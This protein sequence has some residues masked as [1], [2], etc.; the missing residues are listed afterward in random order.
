MSQSIDHQ[1]FDVIVVGGGSAGIAAAISAASNGARTALIESGNLL[2]GELL[3]GMAIDGAISA[4]GEQISGGILD[5]IMERCEHLGGFVRKLNDWRLIQYV[6]YDPEIMKIAVPQ[7]VYEAGVSVFLQTFAEGVVARDGQVEGVLVRNKSGRSLL[8][9][10][11]VV[12]CSGDG[13]ICVAAGSDVLPREAEERL[14]PVSMMFRMAG[15]ETPQLLDF[16]VEHP[17][18]FA[19]GESD[20][21]RGGRTDAELAAEIKR[22]GQPCVFL[23]GDA[24]FLGGAI[25]RGDMYPTALIMIQPTSN[26]RGEV[27]VNST[28][29]TLDDPL[30][31]DN[32]ASAL[33]EL[34]QQIATCSH[35]LQKNVPGFANASLSGVAPK[36]GIRETRR[37]AG[38]YLLTTEDVTVGR[39]SSEGIAKGC[40]HIDIH[41]DGIGQTR[42]PIADGGSY[43]IPFG[44]LVPKT[45]K[46]VLMAGRCFS[47]ERPAHGSA[48]V[49]GGCLA[50]GQAAGTA[51]SMACVGNTQEVDIRNVPVS[52]LRNR[53]M[54][55]GAILEG[56]H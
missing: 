51:A 19:M 47:A 49:M 35:F 23:K 48:R 36:L 34:T 50:M 8:T 20:A 29:I 22:Q 44:C 3:T 21:I 43:D 46:N 55:A 1:S 32:I 56:V 45:L 31:A 24:E 33:K 16:V 10:K 26:A 37:I 12:D 4:R 7:L 28:R 6:V 14:Q 52:E 17:E 42:I 25:D 39:K 54:N 18:F 9:A 15:V 2:G 30:K 40:H 41:E 11:V 27:C 5:R 53:L 38:E 13:D